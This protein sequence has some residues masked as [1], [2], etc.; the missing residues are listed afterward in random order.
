MITPPFSISANPRCT[1]IEPVVLSGCVMVF[2][3]YLSTAAVFEPSAGDTWRPEHV[4]D[5][6]RYGY[7]NEVG[8]VPGK[9]DTPL[10]NRGNSTQVLPGVNLMILPA[11][12]LSVNGWAASSRAQVP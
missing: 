2:L 3:S 9:N 7:L 5:A 4:R 11:V 12:S 8:S 1:R 10:A 6:P